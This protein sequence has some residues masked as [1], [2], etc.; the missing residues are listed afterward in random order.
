MKFTMI[1][2]ESSLC[3]VAF[4]N[5]QRCTSWMDYCYL[6]TRRDHKLITNF[7]GYN[8]WKKIAVGV[9]HWGCLHKEDVNRDERGHGEGEGLTKPKVH[10]E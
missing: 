10:N 8:Q 6:F 7:I 1:V 3:V 5:V 9:I 4:D 2:S